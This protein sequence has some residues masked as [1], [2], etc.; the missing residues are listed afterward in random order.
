MAMWMGISYLTGVG[1][2]VKRNKI[3]KMNSFP[4][5]LLEH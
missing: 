4:T 3:E 2:R 1:T 5:K